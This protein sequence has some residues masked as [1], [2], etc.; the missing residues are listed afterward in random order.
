MMLWYSLLSLRTYGVVCLRCAAVW[1]L[2]T[3]C[4]RCAPAGP[5]LDLSARGNGALLSFKFVYHLFWFGGNNSLLFF[6]FFFF[7]SRTSSHR[8]TWREH[9]ASRGTLPADP[10]SPLLCSLCVSLFLYKV[11]S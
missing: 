9:V 6:S 1:K 5:L 7:E 8:G 11:D 10:S 2:S 4:A 3:C